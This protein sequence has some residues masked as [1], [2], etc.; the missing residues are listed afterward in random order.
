MKK[1][2][3]NFLIVERLGVGV[4]LVLLLQFEGATYYLISFFT[5]QL[6]VVIVWR[7]YSRT[8]HNVRFGMNMLICIV[9]QIILKLSLNNQSTIK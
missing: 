2:W 9:V 3:Y 4:G 5:L 7:P 1:K 8:A 6:L